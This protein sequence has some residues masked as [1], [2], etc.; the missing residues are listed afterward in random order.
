MKRGLQLITQL[1]IQIKKGTSPGKI[2]LLLTK[3]CRY[4]EIW[5]YE[6]ILILSPNRLLKWKTYRKRLRTSAALKA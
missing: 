4:A 5:I 2:S 3:I 6:R 1:L